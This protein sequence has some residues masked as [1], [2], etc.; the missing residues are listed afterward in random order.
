MMRF[1]TLIVAMLLVSSVSKAEG[2]ADHFV[3][4]YLQ[5]ISQSN[6]PAFYTACA[7]KSGA[8]YLIFSTAMEKGVL[9]EMRNEKAVNTAEISLGKNG[10]MAADT[11][12]GTYSLARVDL[13]A[14]DLL[15]QQFYYLSPDQVKTVVHNTP[16]IQ[17]K[18]RIPKR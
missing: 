7:R 2:A 18:D 9:I 17:C 12:G 16:D 5:V 10:V 8:A 11:N 1:L 14:T 3:R 13:L 6:G 4:H 15:A